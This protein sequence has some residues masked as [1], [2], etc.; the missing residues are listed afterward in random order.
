MIIDFHTHIFPDTL[1]PRAVRSLKDG[2]GDFFTPTHN[3]TLAGLLD[4]MDKSEIDKSVVLPVV[5]KRTQ[6]ETVN[7]WVSSINNPRI[8]PFGGMYPMSDDYKEQIDMIV[9]LGLK[10]VKFHAEFQHFTLDDPHMMHVYDYA[11]EKGLIII[12][13]AGSDPA[14]DPPFH[15]NP[16]MFAKV[17]KELK[18]GILIAAHLG[19]LFQWEEVLE[20][21]AGTDI[22]FDTSMAEKYGNEELVE[23]IY[24]KHGADK[25]LFGTDSPWSNSVTAVKKMRERNFSD[26]E[27]E[28]IFHGNAEKLLG[29]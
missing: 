21:L 16:S 26:E 12:H 1:A 9:S 25:L 4:Y 24:K 27:L 17:A 7:N 22:Y 14:F 19:G 20:E 15:S 11:F 3:M 8:I 28:K 18:G 23:A 6:T 29:L 2:A 10:G 5:T 13:H